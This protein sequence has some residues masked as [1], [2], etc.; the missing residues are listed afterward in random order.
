MGF[1][2]ENTLFADAICPDEINHHRPEENVTSVFQ[3]TWGD[4]FPLGG[5]GGLPFV[6]KTGWGA[7]SSHCPESGNILILFAPHVG[8]DLNGTVGSCHRAGQTGGSSACGAA[9]GAYKAGCANDIGN[10]FLRIRISVNND[11]VFIV[12]ERQRHGV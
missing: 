1:T 10:P 11:G 9:I 4:L 8:V 12:I 3:N 2:P 5:L 7:F 6:G